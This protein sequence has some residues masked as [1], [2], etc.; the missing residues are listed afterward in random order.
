MRMAASLC[1]NIRARRLGAPFHLQPS[2]RNRSVTFPAVSSH[3]VAAEHPLCQVSHG[4]ISVVVA[5]VSHHKP[6]CC[7]SRQTRSFQRS[8]PRKHLLSLTRANPLPAEPF[9]EANMAADAIIS[10]CSERLLLLLPPP[11]PIVRYCSLEREF[12]DFF[13]KG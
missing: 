12:V 3:L 1:K 11:P 8:P 2:S 7:C 4:M 10:F 6:C 9:V 5:P 13:W